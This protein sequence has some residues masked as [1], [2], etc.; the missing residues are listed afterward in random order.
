M[1]T[2]QAHYP[3]SYTP[4]TAPAQGT[5]Y[6]YIFSQHWKWLKS[7]VSCFLMVHILIVQCHHKGVPDP[8]PEVLKA[9]PLF[10]AREKVGQSLLCS[11]L[12][13]IEIQACS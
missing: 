11:P 12:K 13:G 9:V 4:P 5:W 10:V 1:H 2:R 7:L 6:S 8:H 3:L